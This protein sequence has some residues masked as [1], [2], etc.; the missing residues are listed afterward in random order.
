MGLKLYSSHRIGEWI[1]WD[2]MCSATITVLGTVDAYLRRSLYI[3]IVTFI[4]IIIIIKWEEKQRSSGMRC[5]STKWVQFRKGSWWALGGKWV[6][7]SSRCQQELPELDISIKALLPA[8]SVP[9]GA[10][11]VPNF[12]PL[13]PAKT[14]HYIQTFLGHVLTIPCQK[15]LCDLD[16]HPKCDIETLY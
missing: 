1:P 8:K 6:F 5:S 12:H 4:I 11:T 3:I 10:H 16:A 7:L 13:Y 2:N 15:I 14:D 9:G